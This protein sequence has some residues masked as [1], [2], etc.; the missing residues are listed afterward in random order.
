[1]RCWRREIRIVLEGRQVIEGAGRLFGTELVQV[2]DTG[3][4]G[5]TKELG[6]EEREAS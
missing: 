6:E 1:M 2:Y 3:K 5:G 4:K